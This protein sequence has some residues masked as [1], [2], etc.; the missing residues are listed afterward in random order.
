MVIVDTCGWIE[1]FTD[2]VL[3]NKFAAHLLA[4][5]KL[6]VPSCIQFELYKWIKREHNEA[7]ALEIIALT[8][9]GLVLPLTTSLALSA[10][11]L[12]LEYKLS[13]ADSL[14]YA[15]AQSRNATLITCDD[16]FQDL[17]NVT[18]YSKAYG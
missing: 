12:A 1:W 9:K 8:E 10:A 2:G 6:L 14:I 7:L 18:F 11:D 4:F 17:A 13:F 16:H 3:A 15:T 5:D